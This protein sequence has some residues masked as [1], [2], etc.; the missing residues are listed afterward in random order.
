[1][2]QITFFFQITTSYYFEESTWITAIGIIKTL[3]IFTDDLLRYDFTKEIMLVSLQASS[4]D[5]KIF[6]EPNFCVIP[7]F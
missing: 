2:V 7:I 4:T 3:K 5:Q 1:M 6:S